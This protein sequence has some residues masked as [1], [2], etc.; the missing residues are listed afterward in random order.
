MATHPRM[1]QVLL[2]RGHFWMVAVNSQDILTRSVNKGNE[3]S[4]SSI[5]CQAV[6]GQLQ[7]QFFILL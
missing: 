4:S 3:T 5:F 7:F 6:V 2:I 1:L